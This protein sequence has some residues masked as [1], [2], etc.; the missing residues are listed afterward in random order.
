M[1]KF[2]FLKN[3]NKQTKNKEKEKN[4]KKIKETKKMK[5]PIF[6]ASLNIFSIS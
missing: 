3:N 4:E 5:P 1:C 2:M 6:R